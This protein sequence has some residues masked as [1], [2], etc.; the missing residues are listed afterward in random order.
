MISA[1][2]KWLTGDIVPR[3]ERAVCDTGHRSMYKRSSSQGGPGA[4]NTTERMMPANVQS[5]AY[6]A[7]P[8]QAPS[9]VHLHSIADPFAV[10]PGLV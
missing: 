8:W 3:N 5:M 2:L 1:K 9:Q 10:L 7:T 6:H 4:L